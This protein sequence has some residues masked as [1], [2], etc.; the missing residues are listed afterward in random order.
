MTDPRY[1]PPLK[2]ATETSYVT[3][4]EIKAHAMFKKYCSLTSSP[5]ESREVDAGQPVDD[6][7][8]DEDEDDAQDGYRHQ[9][10]NLSLKCQQRK[11]LRTCVIFES[12]SSP[13]IGE[14][15]WVKNHLKCV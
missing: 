3:A 5:V 6:L 15:V 12:F 9:T 7:R 10:E 14:S 8:Q 1:P 2:T 11:P 4:S 13:G